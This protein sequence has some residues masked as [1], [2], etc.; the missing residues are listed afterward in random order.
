MATDT[1][2]GNGF[3]G[4]GISVKQIFPT[5]IN[6]NLKQINRKHMKVINANIFYSKNKI[7]LNSIDLNLL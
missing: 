3:S 4:T 7:T 6:K 1:V 2:W 5:F